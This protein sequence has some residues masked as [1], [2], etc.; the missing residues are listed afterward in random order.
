MYMLNGLH[1]SRVGRQNV[2]TA[3]ETKVCSVDD[4]TAFNL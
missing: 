3:T 4:V 2:E 1:S